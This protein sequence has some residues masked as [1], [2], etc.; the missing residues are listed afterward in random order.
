[1]LQRPLV[2][3][4][5]SQRGSLQAHAWLRPRDGAR[6]NQPFAFYT[7]YIQIWPCP[8]S[9]SFRK[10][11]HFKPSEITAHSQF[12]STQVYHK[13]TLQLTTKEAV[14]IE[15]NSGVS[16]YSIRQLPPFCIIIQ[17]SSMSL[18]KPT[19]EQCRSAHQSHP[20]CSSDPPPA[21]CPRLPKCL[22]TPALVQAQLV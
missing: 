14:S 22:R 21:A 20:L 18:R 16:R 4:A 1:M 19:T 13:V 10:R 17:S 9:A 5:G 2:P 7:F 15:Q 3:P 11:A 12:T 6:H 8:S